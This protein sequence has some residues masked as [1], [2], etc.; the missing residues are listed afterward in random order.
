MEEILQLKIANKDFSDNFDDKYTNM[1]PVFSIDNDEDIRKEYFRHEKAAK[2]GD[3]IYI[4]HE[5]MIKKYNPMDINGRD[6]SKYHI[7]KK[8]GKEIGLEAHEE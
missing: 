7:S 8:K 2:K 4:L 3:P 1:I 6:T 5:E